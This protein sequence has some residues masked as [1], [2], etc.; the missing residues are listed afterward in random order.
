MKDKLKSCDTCNNFEYD[1]ELGDY[2][3]VMEMDED[4]IYRL[5]D[6]ES[7]GCPFYRVRDEYSIVRKQN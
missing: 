4:D 6:I 2:I 1:D 7:R 5:G 3:C